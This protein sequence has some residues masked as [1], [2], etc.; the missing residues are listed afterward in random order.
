MNTVKI[1]TH[2]SETGVIFDTE[3]T[4]QPEQTRIRINYTIGAKGDLKPDITSEA[5]CVET[6]MANLNAAYTEL[7]AFRVVHGYSKPEVKA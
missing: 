4:Q 5:E 7:E 1:T 3:T 2:R 6:A